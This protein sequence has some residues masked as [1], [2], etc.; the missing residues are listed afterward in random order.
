MSIQFAFVLRYRLHGKRLDVPP[1][2]ASQLANCEP[3]YEEVRG[4]E[5]VHTHGT[6]IFA[7]SFGSEKICQIHLRIDRSKTVHGQRRSD[8]R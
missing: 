8:A 2:D 6:K 4:L 3:V 7:A 5:Y 1:C